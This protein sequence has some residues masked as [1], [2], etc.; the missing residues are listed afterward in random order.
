[1]SR[2]L[3]SIGDLT[4][5]ESGDVR[6]TLV[7]VGVADVVDAA[8]ARL[9]GAPLVAVRV[10]PGLEA[11]ADPALLEQALFNVLDNAVKY[12]PSGSLIRVA[13]EQ[14][15]DGVELHVADEGVGISADELPR[16]FDSFFRASRGDRV[17][18]GTGLGLAIARGLVEAMDGRIAALSPRPDAPRQGLP[19]T[20]ITIRLR[21]APG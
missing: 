16:I 12:A 7:P 5:L 20:V 18:P 8:V 3:S 21:A 9:P 10:E 11:L 2:F 1:M 6:P 4:R 17:A 14:G 15:R 13:G 19:G